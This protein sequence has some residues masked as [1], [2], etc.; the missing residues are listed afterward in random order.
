MIVHIVVV[1]V[2][3]YIL[4]VHFFFLYLY[5][6]MYILFFWGRIHRD[7]YVFIVI[8]FLVIFSAVGLLF[9]RVQFKRLEVG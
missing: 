9:F 1:V 7:I 5:M 3:V 8:C 2:A 6:Y 4:I